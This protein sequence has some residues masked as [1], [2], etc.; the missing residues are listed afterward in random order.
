MGGKTVHECQP[1]ELSELF[2]FGRMV[3]KNTLGPW[4]HSNC[5]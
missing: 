5:N 2:K 4:C 1:Q 3:A